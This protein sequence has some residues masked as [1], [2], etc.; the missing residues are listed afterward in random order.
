MVPAG[1]ELELVCPRC[2]LSFDSKRALAIHIDK[3]CGKIKELGDD[4][5][6]PATDFKS[7]MT[8]DDVSP[9][10]QGVS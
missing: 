4:R 1:Q 9:P 8:F 3:F 10:S 7:Y 6:G 5:Y 2:S